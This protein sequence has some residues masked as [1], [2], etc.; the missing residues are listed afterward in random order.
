MR[1][2]AAPNP[3]R[4][5]RTRHNARVRA[6]AKAR[7]SRPQTSARKPTIV[8]LQRELRAARA[9]LRS[10]EA[11]SNS[12]GDL[13]YLLG[14]IRT[15]ATTAIG[16]IARPGSS[17]LAAVE[18]LARRV[19]AT[20][21]WTRLAHERLTALLGNNTGYATP[22]LGG[23]LGLVE[24]LGA[25]HAAAI[26]ERDDAHKERDECDA[27]RAAANALIARLA[28]N[29]SE[30]AAQEQIEAASP[31]EQRAV[32]EAKA[33]ELAELSLLREMARD[34]QVVMI[35][36]EHRM[37]YNLLARIAAFL[38]NGTVED[39]EAMPA[40]DLRVIVESSVFEDRLLAQHAAAED[41]A[42]GATK[43]ALARVLDRVATN[44]RAAPLAEDFVDPEGMRRSPCADLDGSGTCFGCGQWIRGPY[45][46]ERDA[47][48]IRV[49]A[50]CVYVV[51]DTADPC[52]GIRVYAAGYAL[53]IPR[54]AV[55]DSLRAIFTY[56]RLKAA[57]H[58]PAEGRPSGDA[59]TNGR[60]GADGAEPPPQT[61]PAT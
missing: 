35:G 14:E 45:N 26:R 7:T 41:A 33:F 59:C 17:A 9:A 16:I 21:A 30:G 18:D 4:T 42:E 54:D 43:T 44:L 47:H 29:L 6:A 25:R 12:A 19:A 60:D 40:A 49:Q 51:D 53:F 57:A 39:L 22:T 23:V 28:F 15:R 2:R 32:V 58:G 34:A 52:N 10:A 3:P 31:A 20:N 8:S 11:R 61:E 13:R 46:I 24:E 5:R 48:S 56:A 38:G 50:G 37:A 27:D 36:D 1:K 55:D